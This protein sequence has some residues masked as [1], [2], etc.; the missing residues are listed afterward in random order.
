MKSLILILLA[1]TGFA[2]QNLSTPA[3]ILPPA[4]AA[5]GGSLLFD[6]ST[7]LQFV[8]LIAPTTIPTIVI[9]AATAASPMVL[10]YATA[11]VVTVGSV[12]VISNAAGV[13]CSI[14]NGPQTVTVASGTSITINLNGTGCTYTASSG[15]ASSAYWTLPTADGVPNAAL[16]TDGA[17]HLSFAAGGAC[18]TCMLTTGGQ[19]VTGV[20]TYTANILASGTPNIGSS[21]NPFNDA[22]LNYIFLQDLTFQWSGGGGFVQSVGNAL[23]GPYAGDFTF[24]NNIADVVLAISPGGGILTGSGNFDGDVVPGTTS[25]YDLGTSSL[26]WNNAYVNTLN[27]ANSLVLTNSPFKVTI[28]AAGLVAQYPIGTNVATIGVFGVTA[29]AF[30]DSGIT[31]STQCVHANSSGLFSGTG[32]DCTSAA[33]PWTSWSPT[34]TNLSSITTNDA[35]YTQS[36][37][38]VSFSFEIGGTANGS[39]PTITLPFTANGSVAGSVSCAGSFG[40]G[41]Y[42]TLT[43]LVVSTIVILGTYN[44][45]AW[46]GSTTAL[47]VCSGTYWTT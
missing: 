13:G 7:S 12:I 10:T 8:G 17:G 6:D 29:L 36:G 1:A 30:T 23:T 28:N 43:G 16:I 15:S 9:T 24:V 46:P 40:G 44:D 35:Y 47:I 20:D 31:G 39:Q 4:T 32:G 41:G 38:T 37:K 45:S 18:P 27:L 11:P 33:G 2:Q 3:Q 42:A 19:T 22:Y 34:I 21:A 25:N 26:Y 5:S 14:M